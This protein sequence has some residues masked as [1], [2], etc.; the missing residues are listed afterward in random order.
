MGVGEVA[1]V[2]RK[3]EVW[4]EGGGCIL[5]RGEGKEKLSGMAEEMGDSCGAI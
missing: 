3:V 4:G 2:I 5:C 1:A